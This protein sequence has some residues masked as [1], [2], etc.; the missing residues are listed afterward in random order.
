VADVQEAGKSNQN[1]PEQVESDRHTRRGRGRRGSG[2]SRKAANQE[3]ESDARTVDASKGSGQRKEVSSPEVPPSP[4]QPPPPPSRSP[5][6]VAPP[7]PPPPPPRE[8]TAPAEASADRGEP[9]RQPRPQ[10]QPQRRVVVEKC[11]DNAREEVGQSSAPSS[12]RKVTKARGAGR[13]Q[14]SVASELPREEDDV[15]EDDDEDDDEQEVPISGRLWCARAAKSE[16]LVM[17]GRQPPGER[18]RTQ[19]E[20]LRPRQKPRNSVP[21]DPEGAAP[22]KPAAKASSSVPAR[23]REAQMA[24]TSVKAERVKPREATTTVAWLSMPWASE[25]QNLTSEAKKSLL[26]TDAGTGW[27][28]SLR[29]TSSAVRAGG[30]TAQRNK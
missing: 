25:A 19:Q 2:I 22:S 28:P 18:Q 23:R 3:T 26:T 30:T 17:P 7:P 14:K 10:R 6:P 4:P 24:A 27:K 5:A 21:A 20:S 13:E 11:Q 15:G 9:Q 1:D 8:A 29:L 16:R 12:R